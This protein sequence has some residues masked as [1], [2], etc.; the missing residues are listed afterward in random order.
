MLI[1]PLNVIVRV[2]VDYLPNNASFRGSVLIELYGKVI[3]RIWV[4][5][6]MI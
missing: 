2:I 5:D 4:G 1:Y 6:V 3:C